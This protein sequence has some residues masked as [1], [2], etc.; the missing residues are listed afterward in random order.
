MWIWKG[1]SIKSIG[2]FGNVTNLRILNFLINAC[3]I[4]LLYLGFFQ[5][6]FALLVLKFCPFLI[7]F[8][9]GYLFW[10]YCIWDCFLIYSSFHLLL[11]YRNVAGFVYLSCILQL[12]WTFINFNFYCYRSKFLHIWP[13]H[14]CRI[15]FISSFWIW[16]SFI[17]FIIVILEFSMQC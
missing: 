9:S 16:M 5:H 4:F 7:K 12:W 3:E 17:S 14:L 8:I 13:W 6:G 10:C 1:N 2:S 15:D 11:V